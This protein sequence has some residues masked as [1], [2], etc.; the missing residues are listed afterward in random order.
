VRLRIRLRM[1]LCYLA[2]LAVA[3]GAVGTFLVLRLRADLTSRVDSTLL[4]A[5][6]QVAHDYGQ[7]GLRE[8]PDSARTVLHGD[9][10][11]GQLLAADG[12]V[13]M[14][15]GDPVSRRRTLDRIDLAA[16]IRGET[17]SRTRNL[18]PAAAPFRLAARP[19]MR[20]G[21]REAVVMG[22]SLEPVEASVHH[23]IVLLG[24]AVPVA[25]AAMAAA[26]WWLARRSLWPIAHI[27]QTAA[28]I[29]AT[30]LDERVEEPRSRDEVAELARTM[31]TMLDRL[32]HAVLGQRRLVADA[33]HELRTPLAAMRSE[34]DVSLR[35]DDLSPA[36]RAVLV[37]AREEVDRM[38]RTVEDLLTLAT[39]DEGVAIISA[40]P[41][42]LGDVAVAVAGGLRGWAAE[43][44]VHLEL[45]AVDPAAIIGDPG[46]LRRAVRNLVENAIRHSPVGGTVRV[47]CTVG[48]A[49]ATI[50]VRDEG[51]GIPAEL[52]TRIF[53]RFFRAD[54]S[55]RRS[56]GG[57][58]LG[59]AISRH[60]AEAHGGR[61]GVRS[62]SQGS[63]FV[64][65][66]PLAP[67]DLPG[68]P[69]APPGPAADERGTRQIST[70]AHT[71]TVRSSDSTR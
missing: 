33:S 42:D 46:Q 23:V 55:R 1:T 9:R 36:A 70:S 41:A 45:E 65:A 60:I 69:D 12:R 48:E 47:R 52:R 66:V 39:A 21:R 16:V 4:P 37:S 25:L 51:P 58:G 29:G 27:T 19:V 31:N 26:G 62:L 20:R 54:P 28:A 22:Q 18:D 35:A 57:S 11:T 17:V 56:T 14:V 10:A 63:A 2:L 49:T 50:E 24:L 5:A 68:L 8:F 38:S 44:G 64:L 61:V 32:E 15:F 43:R 6:G 53:D 67:E 40:E 71:G 34:I 59:L 30:S 7:E 3:L 13:L